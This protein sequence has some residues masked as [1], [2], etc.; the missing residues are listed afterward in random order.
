MHQV[1]ASS[2]K[3]WLFFFLAYLFCIAIARLLYVTVLV[4]RCAAFDDKRQDELYVPRHFHLTHTTQP[5]HKEKIESVQTCTQKA[6][7]AYI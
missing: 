4:L 6:L 5:A 3:L 1:D 7:N 2:K